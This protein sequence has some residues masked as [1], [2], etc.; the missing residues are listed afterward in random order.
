MNEHTPLPPGV[1]ERLAR[2]RAGD[3][4]PDDRAAFEREVLA[5]DALAEALY[6]ELSLDAVSAREAPAV[7]AR[8]AITPLPPPRRPRRLPVHVLLPIAAALAVVSAVMLWRR[9]APV[10][11]DSVRGTAVLRVLEPIGS[12]SSPPAVFRWTHGAGA[13]SYRLDLYDTA[14]GR[15]LATRVTR[16]TVL[17]FSEVVPAGTALV[18]SWR[19]TALGPDGL[20]LNA[21]AGASFELA[22]H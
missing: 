22:D 13:D 16:D 11:G 19:V 10:P 2:Y 20:D 1:E 9:P 5:D 14:S 15:P 8:P 18:A 4:T 3:L 17:A 6:A 12:Q 7:P 21:T